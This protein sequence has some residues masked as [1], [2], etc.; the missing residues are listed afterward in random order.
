MVT[1]SVVGASLKS[2]IVATWRNAHGQNNIHAS[3]SADGSVSEGGG[4]LEVGWDGGACMIDSSSGSAYSPSAAK[5]KA[6]KLDCH[7]LLTE[8]PLRAP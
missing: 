8:P 2:D 5:L 6:E 4:T 7:S 3:Y 1:R